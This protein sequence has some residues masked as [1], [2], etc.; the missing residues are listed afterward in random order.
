MH[1]LLRDVFTQRSLYTQKPLYTHGS[2]QHTGVC[3][4]QKCLH[5]ETLNTQKLLHRKVFTNRSFYTQKFLHT[6]TLLHTKALIH[7]KDTCR[8]IYTQT[9]LHTEAFALTENLLHR[10]AFIQKL[11]LQNGIWAPKQILKHVWKG[12]FKENKSSAP[13][14]RKICWQ[15][16]I[17]T[18]MR[19]LQ[20]DLRRSAAKDKSITHTA[21]AARNLDAT[22]SLPSTDTELQITIER[23]QPRPH[24][25]TW[26]SP[27]LIAVFSGPARTQ[28]APIAC[29]STLT[30]VSLMKQFACDLQ[31]PPCKS[32]YDQ[33]TSIQ[34]CA[35]KHRVS[36]DPILIISVTLTRQFDCAK[37]LRWC[38]DGVMVWWCRV[39]FSA[40]FFDIFR[41]TEFR[42]L[43]FL[44][45]SIYVC[46]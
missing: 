2:F 4:T 22:T 20:Y 17:A 8:S 39:F 9:L 19:P 27:Y 18:L 44:W 26:S 13:K 40:I 30:S 32:Q 15:I 33:H 38:G 45:W 7:K 11:Q 29:D 25:Q 41:I 5:T 1:S 3:N 10:E 31:A 37:E 23:R 16:T 24:T 42:L 35:R 28:A 34:L 12:F 6:H 14:W 46:E 43:N 36:C 21:A